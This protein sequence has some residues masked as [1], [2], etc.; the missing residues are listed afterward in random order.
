M[1]LKFDDIFVE[2]IQMCSSAKSN[3]T[4]I[5]KRSEI[6]VKKSLFQNCLDKLFKWYTILFSF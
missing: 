6:E 1:K 2:P 5:G 3:Q 4:T